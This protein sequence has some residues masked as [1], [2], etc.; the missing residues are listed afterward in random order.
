MVLYRVTHTN[1]PEEVDDFL[2]TW[3]PDLQEF[4]ARSRKNHLFLAEEV[5]EGDANLVWHPELGK[6]VRL[7]ESAQTLITTLEG[8]LLETGR[9]DANGELLE[10]LRG[11]TFSETVNQLRDKDAL[12]AVVNGGKAELGLTIPRDELKDISSHNDVDIHNSSAYDNV[13]SQVR[14]R[15]VVWPTLL[16]LGDSFTIILNDKG[17]SVHIESFQG[18]PQVAQDWL[19]FTF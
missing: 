5:V 18:L 9:T 14:V 2:R 17:L 11:C 10:R 8:C 3:I 13:I 16:R 12:D 7:A 1:T 15:R 19:R 6:I 4:D